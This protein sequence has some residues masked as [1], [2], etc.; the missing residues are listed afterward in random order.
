MS[1]RKYKR[2]G[3]RIIGLKSYFCAVFRNFIGY[4]NY[5]NENNTTEYYYSIHQHVCKHIYI[6][7]YITRIN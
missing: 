3:F 7:I 6:Y 1:E 5:D 2:L 4:Y